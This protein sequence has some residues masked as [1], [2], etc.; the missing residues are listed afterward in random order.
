LPA[1]AIRVMPIE[2]ARPY[3]AYVDEGN[4]L[5]PA[6]RLL[7]T[8]GWDPR[9]YLYPQF[10]TTAATAAAR[11]YALLYGAA[12][13]RALW[14]TRT[15]EPEVY[16]ELEPFELLLIARGIDVFLGMAI[17]VLTALFAR[18]LG[19]ARAGLWAALLAGFT[20]ALVLR[21]S[22]ATVDSWAAVFVLLCLILA[23]RSRT[24]R[25]AGP[26]S[27]SAGALAGC[28]FASKYPSAVVLAA[29]AATTLWEPISN[30]EKFRRAALAA[31]G[32]FSGALLAMPALALH[33]REVRDAIGT[34]AFL[35]SRMASPPLWRQA[36]LRAEWDLP[37][38]RAE[39]GFVLVALAACGFASGCRDRRLAPTV[40][41]WAVYV[42]ACLAIYARQS[43]QPFRNLLPLVP[44]VCI[45][46]AIA[47]ARGEARMRRPWRLR[48]LMVGWIVASCAVPLAAWARE[49]R[50]LVDSRVRAL[51]W[52]VANARPGDRVLI[53]RDLG[54]VQGEL[55]R[56]GG[57]AE[58]SRFRE[59]GAR[60]SALQPRFVV[61][62]VLCR[63]GRPAVE[64]VGE[65][66]LKRD[67]LFRIRFGEAP[68]PPREDWWRGNDQIVDVLERKD[69]AAGSASQ[70][71]GEAAL[72]RICRRES[73]ARDPTKVER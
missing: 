20:P 16:D 36:I 59:L 60:V 29:F 18:R 67:Y 52:V 37:Y 65:P 10:P 49:R 30:R 51:D 34:Q 72:A 26:L 11:A 57:R 70:A 21:A 12:R 55:D 68:T 61:A 5:H 32:V 58:T 45:A 40:R 23:D 73:A 38:D 15:A 64:V 9:S 53:V 47:L 17:V 42:A 66:A 14:R 31:A 56:L 25:R 41:G 39:L 27:F 19:G 7:R 46:A 3:V 54:F 28:A 8:G 50:S 24:H 33:F 71:A 44:L 48:G 22:I 2:A 4:F 35:Y 69:A 43:F 13:G 1:F 62:G 6:A 63:P